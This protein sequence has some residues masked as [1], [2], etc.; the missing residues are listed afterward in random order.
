MAP[1]A[2]TVL[3]FPSTVHISAH[4]GNIE[5]P[6]LSACVCAV[7]QKRF[8]TQIDAEQRY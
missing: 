3:V 8:H 7:V 4:N 1:V 2:A 6:P 5:G